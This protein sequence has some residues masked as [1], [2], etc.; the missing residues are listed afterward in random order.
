MCMTVSQ[1][2]L[3]DSMRDCHDVKYVYVRFIH[4]TTDDMHAYDVLVI[5]LMQALCMQCMDI[6]VSVS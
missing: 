5:F 3:Y 6:Y 4:V 2:H 1:M